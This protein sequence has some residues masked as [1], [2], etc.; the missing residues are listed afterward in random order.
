[1]QE[2]IRIIVIVEGGVVQNVL[3]LGIP[4]QVVVID[5][6]VEGADADDTTHLV[7]QSDG[8]PAKA[9][10][11]GWTA[12]RAS[13]AKIGFVTAFLDS[14]EP[15][16]FWT[17]NTPHGVAVW[18]RYPNGDRDIVETF[19]DLAAAQAYIAARKV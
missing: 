11:S 6:D 12:V 13:P 1:M 7:P 9:F 15:T 18:G 5:Y 19:D 16:V 2:P 3:T 8:E 17:S 14:P 4:A 10:V